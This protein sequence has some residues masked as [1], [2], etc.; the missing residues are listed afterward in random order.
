MISKTDVLSLIDR[1]SLTVEGDCPLELEASSIIMHLHADVY[2]VCPM[3]G[4]D[5][6]RADSHRL[7]KAVSAN[8]GLYTFKRG[9]FYIASTSEMVSIPRSH[10]GL[11]STTSQ[12]ARV[13]VTMLFSSYVAPGFGN[14]TPSRLALEVMSVAADVSIPVGFRVAHLSLFELSSPYDGFHA[15]NYQHGSKIRVEP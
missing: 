5:I 9:R 12:L 10:G 13:G 11:L 8:N 2:E 15:P 3:E 6:R 4:I 7:L 14:L 1:G